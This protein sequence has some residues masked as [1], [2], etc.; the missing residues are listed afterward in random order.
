MIFGWGLGEDMDGEAG[1]GEGG[2]R[3]DGDFQ[4]GREKL[5]VFVVDQET[6]RSVQFYF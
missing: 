1:R 5:V 3:G 6:S 2:G 4:G